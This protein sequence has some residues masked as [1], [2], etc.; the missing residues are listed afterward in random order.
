ML[1]S[2]RSEVPAL[3]GQRIDRLASDEEVGGSIPSG[4]AI[5]N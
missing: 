2:G 1:K 5:Y 3:V 4:G